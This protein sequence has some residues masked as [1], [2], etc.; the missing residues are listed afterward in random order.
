MNPLKNLLKTSAFALAAAAVL[1][2]G[3]KAPA[4]KPAIAPDAQVEARVEQI[5][6]G[7]TLE[8]KV[9]QMVQ[10]TIDYL[11]N[12]TQDDVDPAKMDILFGK[13]RS[14]RS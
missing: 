8:E 5:L 12:E 1:G 2:C 13:Y 14:V 10:I 3:P 11:A 7:M 4:V 9:G 6:K